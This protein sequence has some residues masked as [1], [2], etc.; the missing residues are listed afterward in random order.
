MITVLL[1][2]QTSSSISALFI[3]LG[4]EGQIFITRDTNQYAILTD[5]VLV[6]GTAAPSSPVLKIIQL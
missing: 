5:G 6:G 4:G 3:T 2:Q 1:Q